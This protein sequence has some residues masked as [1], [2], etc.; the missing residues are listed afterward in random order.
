MIPM[1]WYFLS[2]HLDD[3]VLSCGGLINDRVKSGNRTAIIT[4]CAGDPPDPPFSTLALSLHARWDIGP[5]PMVVRRTEDLAACQ[6]LGA[7][8]LHLNIPDCIYRRNPITGDAL[9]EEDEHLFQ[10]L[11]T[12]EFPLADQIGLALTDLIPQEAQVVCPLTLGGHIDH[13]LTR[14]A[15]ETLQNPL[16]YYADYPYLIR[17]QLNPS[18]WIMPG[19]Q[20]ASFPISPAGLKAWI[21]AAAQHQSQISTFWGGLD[22]MRAALTT[23][24]SNGGGSTLWGNPQPS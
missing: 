13:H 7:T 15:A 3:A 1:D 22:E 20:K 19:W 11:P 23:Y 24:W 21:E 4:I 6:R 9:I 12:F 8:A 2:P 5:D 16:L 18:D 14:R 17:D 10:P